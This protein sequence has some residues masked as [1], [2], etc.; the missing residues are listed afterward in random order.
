M[1]TYTKN[2]DVLLYLAFQELFNLEFLGIDLG[3]Y[4]GES[5]IYDSN[6][7]HFCFWISDLSN[8]NYVAHRCRNDRSRKTNYHK[9][10]V[11][12]HFL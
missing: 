9:K 6:F 4:F 5:N 2:E 12:H 11:I 7:L 8:K 10:Q 3:I 1:P